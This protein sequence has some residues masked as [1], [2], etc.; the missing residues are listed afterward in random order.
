LIIHKFIPTFISITVGIFVY[1]YFSFEPNK[2]L[3]TE[4]A[5]IVE[6][7]YV[8]QKT[9][10]SY[11]DTQSI[12]A[13]LRQ[14]DPH[15]YYLPPA[16]AIKNT[17]EM[18]G[19]FVGIG[20]HLYMHL[21]TPIIIYVVPKSPAAIYGVLPGDRIIAINKKSIASIAQL[22]T[23][24]Y[25]YL[26]GIE[27]SI[28][29]LQLFN[30]QKKKSFSKKIIR[31]EIPYSVAQNIYLTANKIGYAKFDVFNQNAHRQLLDSLDIL[32]KKGMKALIL[33]LRNNPGGLLDQAVAIANEFLPKKAIITSVKGRKRKEV[34]YYANGSGKY[35]KLKVY[36]LI[37]ENSASASEILAASLQENK[38]ATVIGSR[39]YGKG[40]VQESYTLINGGN[41]NITVAR[42]YTPKG[43]LLQKH[44]PYILADTSYGIS[45]N[46]YVKASDL[47]FPD[48]AAFSWALDQALYT[49]PWSNIYASPLDFSLA[50]LPN[51]SSDSIL[52]KMALG[53][54]IFGPS[55]H[56][57]LAA[58]QDM[59]L[60]FAL[61][62]IAKKN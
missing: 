9:L 20:I 54:A 56:E 36:L 2:T 35:Q 52:Y 29:N 42:Y 14:L 50:A 3:R 31:K 57:T 32:S 53:I 22:D 44:Y 55:A 41:F 51:I 46:Y 11:K 61:A 62:L 28:C 17:D 26:Q 37:N 47:A 15:S 21:D 33:D 10:S 23:S 45:P 38:R 7:N 58:K 40:L 1:F 39:S 59:P 12:R 60:Q 24:I 49:Q 30:P 27:G 13:W 19:V 25:D 43:K 18:K 4:I 5:H 48:Y 34:F 8:E 16:V 6:T